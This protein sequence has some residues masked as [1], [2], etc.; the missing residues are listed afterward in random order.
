MLREEA[1]GRL[2]SPWPPRDGRRAFRESQLA[3]IF[4]CAPA[5]VH[6]LGRDEWAM[7]DT[8]IPSFWP[9][10]IRHRALN[11]VNLEIFLGLVF[12]LLVA[13]VSGQPRIDRE[14][15]Q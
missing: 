14:Y 2:S 1:H 12:A 15:T 5:A 10:R 8:G 11:P 3:Q 7:A 13:L 9:E 6:R 4:G